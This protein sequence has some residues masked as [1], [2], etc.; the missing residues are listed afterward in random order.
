M[1]AHSRWPS[2]ENLILY[3]KPKIYSAPIGR[4]DTPRFAGEPKRLD[5][6]LEEVT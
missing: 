1:M 4:F 6:T 5:Q 3:K 2:F